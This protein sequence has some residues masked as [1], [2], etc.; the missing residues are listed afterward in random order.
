MKTVDLFCPECTTEIRQGYFRCLICDESLHPECKQRHEER[1]ECGKPYQP[2][3]MFEN[4]RTADEI[5]HD[6]RYGLHR[7][8]DCD[9]GICEWC[10]EESKRR[11]EKE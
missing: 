10:A 3:A 6:R 7:D 8:G 1:G 11:P 5:E 2:S 9:D 4:Y